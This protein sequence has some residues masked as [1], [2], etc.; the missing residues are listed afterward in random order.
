[1]AAEFDQDD[2]SEGSECAS[3]AHDGSGG[4]GAAACGDPE[5]PSSGARGVDRTAHAATTRDG[6]RLHLHRVRCPAAAARRARRL[7]VVLC[8]G[9]GSGGIESF[10]LDASVSLA[11]HLAE[12]GFDVWCAALPGISPAR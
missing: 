8:P 1:M 10:D 7:P 3:S 11:Q 12:R 6:W 4:A 5:E 2:S 9:L